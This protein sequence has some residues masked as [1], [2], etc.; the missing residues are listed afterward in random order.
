[1]FQ[2]SRP[3]NEPLASPAT[4]G[5]LERQANEKIAWDIHRVM[6]EKFI[7]SF[8]ETPAELVLDFDATYDLVHG[9]QEG[10]FFHGYYYS[11]CFCR[12]MYF[13]KAN[14]LLRIYAQATLTVLNTHGPYCLC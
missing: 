5:R 13:A 3:Q 4:L 8:E 12:F 6:V 10:R 7:S 9:K 11:Y 1:M 14:F 2:K